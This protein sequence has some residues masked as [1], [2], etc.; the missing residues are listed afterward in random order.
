[1]ALNGRPAQAPRRQLSGE[2]RSRQL[3]ASAAVR[4][5]GGSGVCNAAAENDCLIRYDWGHLRHRV[6]FR[7]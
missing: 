6:I 4:D 5:R 3:M 1:L 2:D 7:S